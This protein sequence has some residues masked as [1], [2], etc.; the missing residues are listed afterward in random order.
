MLDQLPPAGWYPDPSTPDGQ[1]YWDGNTWTRDTRRLSDRVDTTVAE[2]RNERTTIVTSAPPSAWSA[3]QWMNVL[4]ALCLPV[5][6]V[7][8]LASLLSGSSDD[9][10]P[11]TTATTLVGAANDT[12]N[13]IDD[14][15][16]RPAEETTTTSIPE[17]TT[18]AEHTSDPARVEAGTHA[19]GTDIAPGVYR[20]SIHWARLDDNKNVIDNDLTIRGV[21]IMTVLPTDSFI[22]LSGTAVPLGLVPTLDPIEEGFDQG[23]YLVGPDVTPGRYELHA[24]PGATAFA[25]RLDEHLAAIES[26]QND[27]HVVIDVMAT[28]FALRYTG[29]LQRVDQ[30]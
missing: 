12:P 29:T 18:T 17:T 24:G 5:A 7:V 22:E 2:G 1:R 28:D 15:E 26:V 8:G 30:G 14:V 4:V 25:A 19:V 3:R 16:K 13:S 21:S 23:T 11:T 6:M 9:A 20:V 27:D 10:S